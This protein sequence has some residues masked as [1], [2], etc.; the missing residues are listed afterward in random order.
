MLKLLVVDDEFLARNAV[1]A[2]VSQEGF[3]ACAVREAV[4]GR[5]AMELIGR[6]PPDLALLDVSMPV[7]DGLDLLGWI[8]ENAPSV[9]C[10]ML[11]SY[12]DFEYVRDAMKRGARDYLLKHQLTRQ[13]LLEV[14]RQSGLNSG[15]EAGATDPRERAL[16]AYL[17]GAASEEGLSWARDCL[18]CTLHFPRDAARDVHLESLVKT[19]R[20]LLASEEAVVCAPQD[21][22]LALVFP[23]KGRMPG[24]QRLKRAQAAQRMVMG[25]VDRY[26]GIAL[27]GEEPVCCAT[28]AQLRCRCRARRQMPIAPREAVPL[29]QSLA[30][31]NVL[32]TAVMHNRPEAIEQVL[33]RWFEQAGDNPKAWN[34]LDNAL[35]ALLQRCCAALLSSQPPERPMALTAKACMAQYVRAFA[36]L[37]RQAHR[38]AY[39]GFPDLVRQ[40]LEYLDTHAAEE[41][42]LADVAVRLNVN[43]SYLS[44]LFKKE[45]G[46]GMNQYLNAVRVREAMRLILAEDR[47]ACAVCE[48]VGFRHY[49]HFASVFKAVTGLSPATLRR[50]LQA[51]EYLTAFAPLRP[52]GM[53]EWV[54][55]QQADA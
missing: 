55:A 30:L 43:F 10:V 42:S 2:L 52:L 22:L 46:V 19:V 25:A 23:Q 9:S 21:G 5:E 40:A 48:D 27:T 39:A 36:E 44:S 31:E 13:A 12:S 4:N 41:I 32:T 29:P 33:A 26:H 28:P 14:I 49:G 6:D 24:A 20:H 45:T 34:A 54:R 35:A 15:T 8:Q 47:P 51:F 50:H 53:Q 18:L 3:P 7:M 37:A 11:S 38:V 16:E 17:A 1:Y